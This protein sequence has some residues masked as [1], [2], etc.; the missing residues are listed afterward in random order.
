[1]RGTAPWAILVHDVI[2]S[3][4]HCR[5]HSVSKHSEQW[6]VEWYTSNDKDESYA[7]VQLEVP[8]FCP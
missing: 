4:L 1:M 5:D 7:A 3:V 2:T 6:S 8:G